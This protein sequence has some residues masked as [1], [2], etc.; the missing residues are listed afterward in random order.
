[1]RD[2]TPAAIFVALIGGGALIAIG[3]SLGWWL[4]ETATPRL[5]AWVSSWFART[6]VDG[7]ERTDAGG[8]VNV[9]MR[10]APF[11]HDVE[12]GS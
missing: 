11:T 1:M 8:R 10:L 2:A 7:T 9:S 5:I 6:E 3:A 4:V 12:E